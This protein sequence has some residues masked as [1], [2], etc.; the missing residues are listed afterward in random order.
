MPGQGF[1]I[2]AFGII[3]LQIFSGAEDLEAPKLFE[4]HTSDR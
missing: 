2:W 4:E 3:G 1:R